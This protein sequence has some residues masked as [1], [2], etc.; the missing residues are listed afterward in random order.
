[1]GLSLGLNR[2]RLATIAGAA[3]PKSRLRRPIVR[4]RAADI[5]RLPSHRAL[6]VADGALHL[7]CGI[8][9]RVRFNTRGSRRIRTAAGIRDRESL[10][11]IVGFLRKASTGNISV[12]LKDFFRRNFGVFFDKASIVED[13]LQI[14]GN[15]KG[16]N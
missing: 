1:M 2:I 4:R 5:V 16:K 14:L 13:R 9:S 11:A 3:L 8:L 15:L 6:N 10:A 12:P 7:P